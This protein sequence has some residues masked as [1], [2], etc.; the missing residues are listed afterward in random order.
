[1]S[2]KENPPTGSGI[3]WGA[4]TCIPFWLIVIRLI[5]AGVI[6]VKI[7]ILMGLFFSALLLLLI[8]LPSRKSKRDEQYWDEFIKNIAAPTIQSKTHTQGLSEIHTHA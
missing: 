7:L 1:M 5:I 8:L 4:I 2:Q 6:T 3:I